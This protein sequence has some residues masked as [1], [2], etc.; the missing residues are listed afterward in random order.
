MSLYGE[1]RDISL[2]QHLNNELLG[3]I[4]EQKIGYYKFKLDA[5][6][7][8][9]YGE[10]NTKIYFDP[11]LLNCLITRRDQDTR[12][13]DLGPDRFRNVDFA[14]FRQHLIDAV[15]VPEIGDIIL[16]QE[17]YFEVDNIIENQLF[18]GKQPEYPY[19]TDYLNRFG[20]SIS[21]ICATHWTRAEKLN[22]KTR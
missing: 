13:D 6:A 2:I 9:I 17:S 8:N 7:P 4:I 22:I 11:V 15:L 20:S 14:F 21:M 19:L 3:R 18:V 12:D 10:S 16:W 1:H 5:I